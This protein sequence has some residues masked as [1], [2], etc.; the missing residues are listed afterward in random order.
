[1]PRQLPLVLACAG[2]SPAGRLAYELA[3]ELD[4]RGLAEMTCLAGVGAA[5]PHFLKQLAGREVWI[6][7]GCPIECSRGVFAQVGCPFVVHIRL[8][9]LGVRKHDPLPTGEAFERLLLALLDHAAHV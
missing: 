3:Q 9:D 1:M 4:R 5:K 6:I 8:H 7:D 2:C